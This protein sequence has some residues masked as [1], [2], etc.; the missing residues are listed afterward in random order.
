MKRKQRVMPSDP[1]QVPAVLDSQAID[2]L[3]GLEPVFEPDA[4]QSDAGVPTQF[5]PLCCPYCGESYLTCIDLTNGSCTYVEDCQV[6][7]QPMELVLELDE[8]D[9]LLSFSARRLD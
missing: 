8:A 9:R 6:C 2:A 1:A 5:M 4:L 7:C 3:Y